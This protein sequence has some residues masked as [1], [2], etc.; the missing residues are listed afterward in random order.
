MVVDVSLASDT[1]SPRTLKP[2]SIR[3]NRV[4]AHTAVKLW[5]CMT[6]HVTWRRWHAGQ[7]YP[8][9]GV[10][11]FG[12]RASVKLMRRPRFLAQPVDRKFAYSFISTIEMVPDRLS[13]LRCFP[14]KPV[15]GHMYVLMRRMRM[16]LSLFA[17]THVP[18]RRHVSKEHRYRV[19]DR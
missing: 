19:F 18:P 9:H 2:H 12:A 14:R 6:F 7:G 11:P 10:K 15:H 5:F 13:S 4:P 3:L 17:S 8:V 1:E 16:K